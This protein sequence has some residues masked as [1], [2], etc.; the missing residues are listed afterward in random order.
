MT[1]SLALRVA[2]CVQICPH[3]TQPPLGQWHVYCVEGTAASLGWDDAYFR[4][5]LRTSV[6]GRIPGEWFT[7]ATFTHRIYKHYEAYYCQLLHNL[8]AQDIHGN[9]VKIEG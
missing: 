8:N 3:C 5:L 9:L 7:L 2:F 4:P 6:N 1:P